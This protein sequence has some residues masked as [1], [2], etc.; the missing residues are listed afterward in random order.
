MECTDGDERKTNCSNLNT[1][2]TSI[3]LQFFVNAL[4]LKKQ[5]TKLEKHQNN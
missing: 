5:N 2:L 4:Q 3:G 1:L